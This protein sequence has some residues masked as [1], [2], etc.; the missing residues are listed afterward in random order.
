M[1]ALLYILNVIF[2]SGQVT[3][4]KQYAKMGGKA[5]DFNIS[6]AI[7]GV[8]AFVIMGAFTG[9]SLHF[10]TLLF[11]GLYGIFLCVSMFTGFIALEI[12]PMA[13]TSI[14]SSFSLV[15]PLIAGI[16]VWGEQMSTA[17]VIGVNLM[18]S[19]IVMINIKKEGKI[20][21]R[22][23]ALA[24]LTMISN[25]I[26]SIIQKMHQIRYPGEHKTEFMIFAFLVVLIVLTFKRVASRGKLVVS[27]TGL[28][29]GVMNGASNYIVLMLAA[30]VEASLLFP[31]VSVTNI[32]AIWLISRVM[33]REKLKVTQLVG[34]IAG[35]IS[36]FLLNI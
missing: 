14:I 12:G 30:T 22:W 20:S 11:G 16:T 6:K 34:V 8:V 2:S 15:I 31:M 17:S 24:I 26:C 25:G 21:P 7:A 23:S 36:I 32:I 27:K 1:T 19:S 33:F 3:L 18:L 29:A 28:C 13:L 35:L 5:D 4:G 10:P 9:A